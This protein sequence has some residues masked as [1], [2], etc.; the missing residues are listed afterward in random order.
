MWILDAL[1]REARNGVVL[2]AR[3]GLHWTAVLV[4]TD[5]VQRLGLASTL[6]ASGGAR[7]RPDVPEAGR[8]EEIPAREIASWVTGEVGP[9]SS[10]GM[11]ALNALLPEH[12]DSWDDGNA[13]EVI[14]ELGAGMTVVLVGRFPFVPR[15]EPRVGELLVLDRRDREGTLPEE[16]APDVV[17]RA[18]I[19]AITGQAVANG[20]LDGLLRLRRK[21]ATVLLLGPTTPLSTV[22]FEHGIDCLS[23]AI[24]EAID[25]V[26]RALSQGA[27]F[28]QLHGQGIRLVTMRRTVDT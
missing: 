2:D 13:E 23:G 5:G 10:L 25:P 11:A 8:L 21:G 19:L 6:R 4:E 16:A 14:A 18:D 20:T 3:I 22:M 26:L 9:R 24:V 28:R 7:P 15:L 1:L 27:S 17:P 12:P